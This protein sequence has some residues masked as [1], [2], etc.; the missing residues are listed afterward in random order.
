MKSLQK[1]GGIAA[2]YMATAY[3]IGIVLFIFV[4]DYPHIVEPSQKVEL[5]VSKPLVIYS[6][7]LLMY[8]VFGIA[9]VVFTLALYERLRHDA[10]ST[11]LVAS[12][13]GFIWSGL[14]IAGGMVSNAGIEPVIALWKKDPQQASLLWSGVES[15]ANGLS[16]A[17]GEIL[18][19]LLVLLISFCA[20]RARFFPKA[21][22]ILGGLVGAIGIVS[23]IPGLKD[24]NSLF[25]MSQ[26]VWFVW[27][28]F[29]LLRRSA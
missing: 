28:G 15:V 17:H 1:W 5:L 7:N 12:V 9:L 11:M 27:I 22:I 26:G 18:G 6:T 4:L 2:L 19:G 14:L 29:I 13:I 10:P 25:G 23:I 24:L 3:V 20:S 8:V 21:L 16:C